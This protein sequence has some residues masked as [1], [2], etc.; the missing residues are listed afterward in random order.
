MVHFS[1][2]LKKFNL[3]FNQQCTALTCSANPKCILLGSQ[4]HAPIIKLGLPNDVFSQN[5][6]IKM[7]FKNGGELYALKVFDRLQDK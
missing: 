7:Y 4:I 5:N 2:K 1:S 6:I 3:G